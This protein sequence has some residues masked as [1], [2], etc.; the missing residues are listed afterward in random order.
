VTCP[1]RSP[2]GARCAVVEPHRVHTSRE[3]ALWTG[4]ARD[5]DAACDGES[6][7][8]ARVLRWERGV[9]RRATRIVPRYP[10]L[11]RLKSAGERVIAGKVRKS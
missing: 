2:S 6:E 3:G 8:R 9:E 11:A 10:G 5:L 4:D 1:A 7:E